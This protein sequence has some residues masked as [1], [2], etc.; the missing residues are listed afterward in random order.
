MRRD[1]VKLKT[2]PFVS[3]RADA[4]G[5]TDVALTSRISSSLMHPATS[6]L[7]LN[8]RSEAPMSRL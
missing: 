3:M 6:L 8:T 7:F 5:A 1:G 4:K 2:L